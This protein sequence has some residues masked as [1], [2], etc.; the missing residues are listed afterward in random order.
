MIEQWQV[1]QY[2]QQGFLVVEDV[3]TGE[4]IAALQHDF[5]QWVEE[6]RS[7]SAPWG[8]TQ[9]GRSRF[10]IESDHSAEHPSLRRVSS[11]N[12][13]SAAYRHA[14][15]QS[16]MAQ[17]VGQLIGGSGARYHHSKINSKL[18][19]TATKVEWHQ[20]F[21]FTPHS[22]DDIVTALLMVSEVTPENG[23]LNVVPGS[24]RGP[25]YSHWQD[26]RFTGAVEP[27]V[28]KEQC[29]QPSACFGPS[30]SVCFMHTRL[31]HASSPNETEWP[32]TLFIAVYA[33]EDALPFGE[34]PLPSPDAGTLVYGDE[35]GMV[36]STPNELRLPQKPRGASFFVQQAGQDLAN[37]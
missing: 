9:D 8:D 23:P 36:R 1:D 27:A 31:L 14:A 11:P 16:R 17:I 30:G 33:A 28:V 22:N 32:R 21:L 15:L 3:L 35:S 12:D 10:D 7:Q 6:S 13:I 18:P 26:G 20:D 25:L 37:V 2:H 29:Q 5:D 34:N 24:H 19:H 4:E